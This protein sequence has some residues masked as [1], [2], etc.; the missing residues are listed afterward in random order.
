MRSNSKNADPI[1]TIAA[2]EM[3]MNNYKTG[4]LIQMMQDQIKDQEERKKSFGKQGKQ[5][6]FKN[7]IS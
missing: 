5:K 1:Q 3:A 6:T 2:P 4:N 7:S